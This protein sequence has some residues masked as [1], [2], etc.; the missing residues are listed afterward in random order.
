[1]EEIAGSAAWGGTLI[2]KMQPIMMTCVVQ[3]AL[4]IPVVEG[5]AAARLPRPIRRPMRRPVAAMCAPA[6][7]DSGAT[8]D[9]DAA[10]QAEYTRR[11]A[12]T[13]QWRPEGRAAASDEQIAFTRTQS[14][15]AGVFDDAQLRVQQVCHAIWSPERPFGSRHLPARASL[16]SM[17]GAPLRCSPVSG[18]CRARSGRERGSS[19]SA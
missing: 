18:P 6:E 10:W 8:V 16:V 3:L 13:Q 4:L 7:D 5:M 15:V 12:G 11:K 1:M 2:A 14:Q 19:G 9:W 17:A